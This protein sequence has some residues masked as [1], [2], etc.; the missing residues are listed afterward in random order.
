[1]YR[2]IFMFYKRSKND[3]TCFSH[4]TNT[5][6]E[7]ARNR[8]IKVDFWSDEKIGE[9]SDKAK[10]M[11]IGMWN[12]ADDEG[13][14]RANVPY[15]KSCIFPYET[16]SIDT[17]NRAF[18]ELCESGF[19][20]E[21]TKNKEKYCIIKSFN[22][23]QVINKK[24]KSRNPAPDYRNCEK[25][26]DYI[27][28]LADDHC[29]E[30]GRY[31]SIQKADL[32][33][34]FPTIDHI[35]PQSKGGTDHPSNLRVIC[36][37][38]NRK[39]SDKVLEYLN[40]VNDTV[41]VDDECSIKENVKVKVNEK[42]NI[43][44]N[45]KSNASK[46][47]DELKKFEVIDEL[48]ENTEFFSKIS[49]ATQ[50]KFVATYHLE[51]IT[52]CVSD[53]EIWLEDNPKKKIG[54]FFGGWLKRGYDQWLSKNNKSSLAE[55]KRLIEKYALPDLTDEDQTWLSQLD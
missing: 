16:E 33:D 53:A 14:I 36:A 5:G 10:L 19:I 26:K 43:K 44:A 38:C 50:R 15:I 22:K 13:I 51:Y 23:H 17:Y 4:N 25:Y 52:E 47:V 54:A 39:K 29:P 35:F 20:L 45:K 12:F 46:A 27:Y 7:M 2:I 49:I 1:M 48:S 30:C 11:F 8:M 18:L 24:Q 9:L 41:V 34:T 37:S 6:F 42:E 55:E 21:Y 31:F 3:L 28:S 40:Y 32:Y